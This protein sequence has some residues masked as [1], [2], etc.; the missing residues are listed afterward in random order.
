MGDAD[1]RE[2]AAGAAHFAVMIG[3]REL[4]GRGLGTRFGAMLHAFA[5]LT[6]GLARVRLSIV[7]ANVAGR[8]SYEKLGYAVDTSPEARDAADEPDD[9][10]MTLSRGAFLGLHGDLARRVR[11]TVSP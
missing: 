3:P 1:L 6:L 7:P 8:R 2:F 4:Q 5:F 11:V 10:C 9:V